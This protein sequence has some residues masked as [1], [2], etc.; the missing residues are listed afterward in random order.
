MVGEFWTKEEKLRLKEMRIDPVTSSPESLKKMGY[1]NAASMD[2]GFGAWR[3]A[4][5]PIE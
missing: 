4:G 3:Q 5:F 1:E 2:G